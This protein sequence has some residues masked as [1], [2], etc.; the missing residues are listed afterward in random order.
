MGVHWVA[1]AALA[2]GSLPV[3]A[4]GSVKPSGGGW[5][6]IT[7]DQGCATYFYWAFFK[8][9]YDVTWS[10]NCKAGAPISGQGTLTLRQG[11]DSGFSWS[12]QFVNGFLHGS[13]RMVN[14][15]GLDV[16]HH[17]DK[18]CVPISGPSCKAHRPGGPPYAD[19]AS[20]AQAD[21]PKVLGGAYQP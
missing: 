9:Q 3:Q 21:D 20:K 4:A 15:N 1:I 5:N 11:D 13:A 17:Y 7:T 12:G 2:C 16:A 10:G 8:Y 14:D 6:V 18:G 19:L